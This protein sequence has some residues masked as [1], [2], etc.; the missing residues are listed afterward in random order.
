MATGTDPMMRA[1]GGLSVDSCTLTLLRLHQ[2]R[3]RVPACALTSY[4][5]WGIVP[6]DGEAQLKVGANPDTGDL[7]G[8][9]A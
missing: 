3:G 5:R 7:G 8:A 6:R 4:L 9:I 1:V 2:M